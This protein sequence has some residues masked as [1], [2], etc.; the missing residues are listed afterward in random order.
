MTKQNRIK[1]IG[2]IVCL[3]LIGIYIVKGTQYKQKFLPRTTVAGINV[4]GQT[5]TEAEK[6]LAQHFNHQKVTLKEGSKTITTFTGQSVGVVPNFEKT[7]A[8]LKNA[9]NAWSWPL[10]LFYRDQHVKSA[11]AIKINQTTYQKFYNQLKTQLSTGR[12]ANEAATIKKVNGTFKI[13]DAVQGNVVSTSKLDQSIKNSLAKGQTSIDLK[14]DYIK[15]KTTSADKQNLNNALAKIKKLQNVKVTYKIAGHTVTV[16]QTTS[17]AWL[18]Y[19]NGKVTLDAAK[20]KTYLLSLNSKYATYGKSINFKSTKRGTVKVKAGNYGWSIKVT[21]ETE[22][23]TKDMLKGKDV[24]RTPIHVGV[25]YGTTTNE[26]IGDTYVEVD[27]TNQHMWIYKNGKSVLDT[28]VVTGKP[29][30]DTPSGVYF[31]WNKQRNAT[32]KGSNDDGSSYASP[33]SYWMP[34]DYTGVGIHDA[35]WQPKFGGDWYKTHGSH[36]CV[37]TPPSTMAK[38]YSLVDL[39]T[40]VIIF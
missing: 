37:N 20:V 5:T 24:T 27:K 17:S 38:V 16:P 7:L 32:L 22:A 3:C 14:D 2:I 19:A 8:N 29:G 39:D 30:Q 23:L 34:V 12:K 15:V 9:Q 18:T 1:L 11:K 36:G 33:V 28:D 25:G 31:V 40:P 4:G 35:S 21:S 26:G 10:H 6:T 13:I